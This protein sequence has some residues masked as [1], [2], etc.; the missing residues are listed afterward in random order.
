M[1]ITAAGASQFAAPVVEGL[2]VADD[3]EALLVER[4]ASLEQTPDDAERWAS[5]GVALHAHA[6]ADLAAPCYRAALQLAPGN[7]K[8]QYWL[9]LVELERGR[10][11][12]G[13]GRLQAVAA[14]APKAAQVRWRLGNSYLERGDL[15]LAEEE[16]RELSRLLPAD[17]AGSLGLARVALQRRAF[18]EAADRSTEALMLN[19]S[20]RY[21]AGLLGASY[22]G[23]GELERARPLLA[24]SLGAVE[25]FPDPWFEEIESEQVGWTHWLSIA[26]QYFASGRT[27]EAL[28]RLEGALAAHP[29]EGRLMTKLA[30]G[31]L[32]QGRA[33]DAM[34]LLE[35]ARGLDPGDF[36]VYLHLAQ[37]HT[38]LGQPNLA[39]EQAAKTIEINPDIWQ[40][41]VIRAR[42]LRGLRRLDESASAFDRAL[43]LGAHQDIEV[44]LDR[45]ELH[46]MGADWEAALPMFEQAVTDYPFLARGVA[47]LAMCQIRLGNLDGARGTLEG[48]DERSRRVRIAKELLARREVERAAGG[49][50]EEMP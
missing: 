7:A 43:E 15:D 29:R 44:V 38:I 12:D 30:E 47:G 8:W 18:G 25:V 5:L 21:A 27:E 17:A 41:H 14:L 48:A 20:N 33:Q 45:G 11:G 26:S 46:M 13:L 24:A 16:F 28:A 22:R 4:R 50:T 32:T 23:L 36:V 9:A 40:P 49:A 3:V 37:A 2:G 42:V 34:R 1:A 31:Y 35:T 6:L 39:L 19:P 10:D